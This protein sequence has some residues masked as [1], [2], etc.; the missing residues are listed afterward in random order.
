MA[1]A[2]ERSACV[3]DRIKGCLLYEKGLVCQKIIETLILDKETI[4]QHVE[5][6]K[7]KKK[8]KPENS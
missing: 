8:L 2:E 1:Q 7:K 5:D 4:S 3:A 6:Y